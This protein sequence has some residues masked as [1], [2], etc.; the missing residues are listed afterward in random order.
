M[1]DFIYLIAAMYAISILPVTLFVY[2]AI[3]NGDFTAENTPWVEWL[4]MVSPAMLAFYFGV[5]WPY[6]LWFG[7]ISR[8]EDGE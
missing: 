7:T 2:N 6:W 1:L 3:G 8:L 4:L 5:T